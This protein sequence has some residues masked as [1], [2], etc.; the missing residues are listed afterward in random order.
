MARMRAILLAGSWLLCSAEA[1]PLSFA[2][3]SPRFESSTRSY[4][5]RWREEGERIAAALEAV[6]GRP[7]P[8]GSIEVI[9]GSGAPMTSYDGRTIRLRAGYSPDDW[10]AAIS[11]E[12]GHRLALAMPRTAGIDDHRLL[13]LFL[14]DAWTDLYGQA[15][16][17]RM[18]GIERRFVDAYDYDSAW[19]WA[20]AMTRAERQATLRRIAGGRG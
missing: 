17:D 3:V 11:H 20:L 2:A 1:P 7:F 12:L 13:Y 8:T 6:A 15:F 18:V 4:E 16:A 5:A 9:I 10:R 14:Y 19:R